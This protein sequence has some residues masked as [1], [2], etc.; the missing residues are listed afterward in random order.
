MTYKTDE[1]I[2]KEFD[3]KFPEISGTNTIGTGQMKDYI[4]SFIHQVRKEDRDVHH[5]EKEEYREAVKKI[6]EKEL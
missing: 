6:I 1:Q 2:N 4:K 5:R 3:E